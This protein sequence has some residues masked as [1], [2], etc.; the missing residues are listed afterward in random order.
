MAWTY[1][2][3]TIGG[4]GAKGLQD[5][6]IWAE[7]EDAINERREAV[8]DI[9]NFVVKGAVAGDRLWN[10]A[11]VEDVQAE[12]ER[13]A[14]LY[15]DHQDNAGDWTGTDLADIAP[16][17]TWGDETIHDLC[18]LGDIGVPGNRDWTRKLGSA[19]DSIVTAYGRMQQN[20][21]AA[22]IKESGSHVLVPYLN[23][24]YRALD[25]MRWTTQGVSWRNTDIEIVGAQ[26]FDV[27]SH[28]VDSNVDF[29]AVWTDLD[30]LW[31]TDTWNSGTVIGPRVG[32]AD[33]ARRMAVFFWRSVGS[34][35]KKGIIKSTRSEARA[36]TGNF[37]AKTVDLYGYIRDAMHLEV[38][39]PDPGFSYTETFDPD[40]LP[41][42][43]EAQKWLLMDNSGISATSTVVIGVEGD[44]GT[45][46]NRPADPSG[47][48]D[49]QYRGWFVR[50][51]KTQCVVKYNCVHGFVKVSETI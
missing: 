1:F 26:A 12:I 31:A 9:P 2:P 29:D 44:L 45:L 3:L 4:L 32:H 39:P 27:A 20:D 18:L 14:L 41:P 51:D 40:G 5:H 23:E 25:L 7:F 15:V 49:G 17:Y 34:K 36:G 48:L 43:A 16:S 19:P 47:P 30:L 13:L 50:A 11:D 28:A 8:G 42:G 38:P 35:R 33:V 46:P 37:A 10:H 6:L 22:I 24:M 21:Y